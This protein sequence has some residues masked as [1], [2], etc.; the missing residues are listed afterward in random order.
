MNPTALI[1]EDEP[2]LAQALQAELAR[3]WP[4]LRVLASVGDGSSAVQQALELRPDVQF[5]DVRMPGLD[6]P[7]QRPHEG[8]PQRDQQQRRGP[9]QGGLGPGRERDEH[10]LTMPS[11]PSRPGERVGVESVRRLL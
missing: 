2:L 7:G 4:E 8:Q 11:P 10:G 3:A 5:F 9:A 6:G 1:A